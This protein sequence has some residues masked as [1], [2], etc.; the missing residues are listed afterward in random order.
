M[1]LQSK[2]LEFHQAF[3]SYIAPSLGEVDDSV[4][5]LRRRL[6][7][8]EVNEYLIGEENNDIENIAKELADILYIAFG[9]AVSYGFDLEAVFDEVHRSNMS[10]LGEDGKPVYREDGKILKGPSY[11]PADVRKVFNEIP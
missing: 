6:M 5:T 1:S 8:E 4:R 10:K 9:T 2:V 3:G 11:S 7:N